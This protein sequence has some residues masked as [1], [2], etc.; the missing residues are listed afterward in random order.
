MSDNKIIPKVK[1]KKSNKL[2][3]NII[4]LD[5][6]LHTLRDDV[7]SAGRHPAWQDKCEKTQKQIKTRQ[8]LRRKTNPK[9]RPKLQFQI[10]F[11]WATAVAA[12]AAK[13]AAVERKETMTRMVR[14]GLA[15]GLGERV[16]EK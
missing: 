3:A 1:A 10:P 15:L 6:G 2:Q 8:N 4:N 13:T 7:V 14:D 16:R 5:T 12:Q 9:T 11:S